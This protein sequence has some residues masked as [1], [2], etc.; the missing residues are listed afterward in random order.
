[1][2]SD[3]LTRRAWRALNRKADPVQ[4][5]E[6]GP[7]DL[8]AGLLGTE[9]AARVVLDAVDGELDRLPGLLPTLDLLP[10]I[11]AGTA[12]RLAA[13]VE[14]GRRVDDGLAGGN[15]GGNDGGND[16]ARR[17]LGGVS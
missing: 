17:A 14:L 7:L 5:S 9:E 1:M 8:L 12:F 16:D 10:G 11:G 13:A 3:R 6:L 2:S 15:A 4:L